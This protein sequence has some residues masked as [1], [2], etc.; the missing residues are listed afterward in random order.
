MAWLWKSWEEYAEYIQ[1]VFVNKQAMYNRL[2]R[3]SWARIERKIAETIAHLA[4][5]LTELG[6]QGF[7]GDEN[8]PVPEKTKVVGTT[9][10]LITRAIQAG[11]ELLLLHKRLAINEAAYGFIAQREFFKYWDEYEK[12]N[13]LDVE[14]NQFMS[15]VAILL[16]GVESVTQQDHTVV[17]ENLRLPPELEADFRLARNLFS[18]GFDDVGLLIAARGLESVLRK[19]AAVRKIS[20]LKNGKSEPL[21]EADIF[22]LIEGMYRVSWKKTGRRLISAQNRAL[23][24]YLR[25]LRNS[26]AHGSGHGT[27]STINP[28]ETAIVI[29]SAANALWEEA[30]S[31][32][33]LDPTNIQKT[34]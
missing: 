17:I 10:V 12:D 18:I 25:T 21:W 1:P 28:R 23:L 27:V 34:W 32:A 13:R 15:E 29:A 19:I 24:H 4:Q 14:I 30:S 2:T 9:P 31:K 5:I 7:S 3:R 11:E 8:T 6:L 20:L 22:D 26:G 16:R 33:R